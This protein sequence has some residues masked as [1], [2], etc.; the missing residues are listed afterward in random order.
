MQNR[1]KEKFCK[2]VAAAALLSAEK[3]EL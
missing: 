2:N 1:N 3:D